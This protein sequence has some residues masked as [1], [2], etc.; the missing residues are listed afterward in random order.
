M[1]VMVKPVVDVFVRFKGALG[2]A[3]GEREQEISRLRR[4]EI[5]VKG[6]GR[7]E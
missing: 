6:E 5:M 1:R 2:G 4:K 7:R 3:G